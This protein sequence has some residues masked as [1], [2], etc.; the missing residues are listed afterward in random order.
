M[1][2][3]DPTPPTSG[4]GATIGIAPMLI[5]C[6]QRVISDEACRRLQMA[7]EA[8]DYARSKLTYGAGNQA[9]AM[10]DTNLNST[11]RVQVARDDAKQYFNYP[12][13][14]T[15]LAGLNTQSQIAELAAKAELAQG[16]NCGEHAMVAYDYLRR[17][18]PDEYLQLS[19]KEG[20]DHA[21]VIIGDPASDSSEELVVADPWPTSPTPVLWEDHFAYTADADKLV[22]IASTRGDGRDYRREMIDAGLSLTDAGKKL[23][24][25]SAS[26]AD[27]EKVIRDGKGHWGWTHSDTAAPGHHLQYVTAPAVS[28]GL[29]TCPG[30]T[31]SF[32]R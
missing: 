20:L 30:I 15:R 10:A 17:T 24:A 29:V 27:T 21:F 12:D 8:H 14:A 4:A 13:G 28:S 16:G 7:Q 18:Y 25:H 1:P 23:I 6:P 26:D 9:L 19:R 31:Q 3:S 2:S 22:A 5:R 32:C 11:Y